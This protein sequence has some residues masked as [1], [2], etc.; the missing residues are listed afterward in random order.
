MARI[1]TN[2]DYN[3]PSRAIIERLGWSTV[4]ELINSES[5]RMVY[6]S[7]NNLA[8][9]YLRDIFEKN[10][11]ISSFNLRNTNTD[12]RIPMKHTAMGPKR[13]FL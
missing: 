1:I 2:S 12:L 8:P 3:S 7:L 11:L 10:S 5:S 9:Q 6:K 13:I 4:E